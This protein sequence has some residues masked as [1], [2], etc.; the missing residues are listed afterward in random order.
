M[1]QMGHVIVKVGLYK[2]RSV[3][4][5]A[6]VRLPFTICGHRLVVRTSRC[7]R[8]NVGSIPA[9]HSCHRYQWFKNRQFKPTAAS[10]LSDTTKLYD[11]YN[12]ILSQI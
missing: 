4:A 11:T 12:L 7:G 2:A 10:S 9:A 1:V 6:R 8:E 3:Y 5:I